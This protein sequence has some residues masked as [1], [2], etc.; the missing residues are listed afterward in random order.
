MQRYRWGQSQSQSQQQLGLRVS[1]DCSTVVAAPQT[2]SSC[3]VSGATVLVVSEAG[4]DSLTRVVELDVVG[5]NS[6]GQG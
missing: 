2:R 5:L 1:V 4:V 6:L 3:K